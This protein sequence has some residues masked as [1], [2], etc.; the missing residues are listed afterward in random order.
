MKRE[1]F[2]EIQKK[3]VSVLIVFFTATWC[4]PCQTIKPYVNTKLSKSEYNYLYLDVDE[5]PEIYS[6]FR[7]KKQVRGIPVLLAFKAE[8]VSYIP[9]VSVSGTN[10]LEIDGFFK[11]L[12]A[13]NSHPTH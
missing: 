10:L 7:A 5:N 4:K 6:S 2:V 9:N 13:L 11:S 1:E 12:D 3:N 8:N